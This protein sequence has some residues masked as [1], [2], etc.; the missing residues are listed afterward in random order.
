MAGEFFCREAT[1]GTEVL[2]KH[3]LKQNRTTLVQTIVNLSSAFKQ[4]C[5]NKQ[6]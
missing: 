4:N 3:I 1:N 5:A 2:S 6:T